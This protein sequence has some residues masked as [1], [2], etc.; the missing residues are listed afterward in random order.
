MKATIVTFSVKVV[1]ATGNLV[2][3]EEGSR[4]GES[5]GEEIGVLLG[6]KVIG[7]GCK[8][9]WE[10][11]IVGEPVVGERVRWEGEE[12]G[13]NEGELLGGEL[14][15]VVKGVGGR[16]THFGCDKPHA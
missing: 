12:V 2:G 13:E 5:V 1:Q 16:V 8:V 15:E 14:G 10:G 6:L 7:D 4:K 3:A 11:V 9:E